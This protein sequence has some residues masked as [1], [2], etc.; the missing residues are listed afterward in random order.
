MLRE[1][2]VERV[3]GQPEPAQ[4]IQLEGGS[5]QVCSGLGGLRRPG[6][7]VVREWVSEVDRKPLTKRDPQESDMKQQ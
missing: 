1:R 2:Y 7:R 4:D 6:G 5:E 3:R